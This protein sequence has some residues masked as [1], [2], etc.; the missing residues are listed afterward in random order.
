M[1]AQTDPRRALTLAA[2]ARGRAAGDV[3]VTS[4]AERAMGLAAKELNDLDG[5]E[6]HLRRAA[7]LAER[8]GLAVPEAEA[9]MSLALTLAYRGRTAAALAQAD[10][11]APVLSGGDAARLQMQRAVILD[12]LGRPDEALDGYRRALTVFRQQGDGL[13]E[14]RLLCNRGVLH[15]YRSELGAARADLR[16]ALA[17]SEQLGQLQ[18]VG[19][20]CHNLGFVETRAGDVPGALAW[21]DRA[22]ELWR[23]LEVPC[24]VLLLDRSE[25][26]LSVGLYEE[27]RDAAARAVAE[28]EGAS[29]AIDLA[30]ARLMLAQAAL[31]ADDPG[32][33]HH[34]ALLAERAFVRQRRRSWAVLARYGR[35]RAAWASGER[36]PASLVNARRV[37]GELHA[38][39]WAV[40][41]LDARLIAG[42][43]ALELG[44]TDTARTELAKAA[45]ARRRG[46]VDL[47]VRAWHAEGLRR[48]ADGDRRGADRAL[49][50]GVHLVHRY[51][52]ALGAADLRAHSASHGVELAGVGLR[53]AIG[54]GRPDR[55][56]AWAE[57]ARAGV[58]IGRPARPPDDDLLVAE[59]AELRQV[60]GEL[61]GAA[62]DGRPTARL[63]RRRAELE[64]AVRRR[65]RQAR[66][67][68]STPGRGVAGHPG[69]ARGATGG[70]RHR[71]PVGRP[72]PGRAGRHRRR[73]P[74]CGPRSRPA[75]PGHPRRDHRRGRPGRL[76]ALRPAATGDRS[77]GGRL[78]GGRP[79][80][81]RPRR[82]GA[83]VGAGRSHRGRGRRPPPRAHP[84]RSAARH[85]VGRPARPARPAGDGRPVGRPV[86]GRVGPGGRQHGG[87][88]GAAPAGRRTQPAA[89]RSPWSPVR[90]WPGLRP[91]SPNWPPATRTR[92]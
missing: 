88:A 5:A 81:V 14:A 91:R 18:L 20:V 78:P 27:G 33:A 79:P 67:P 35:A 28:L 64:E 69:R 25:L 21:Y 86:A 15:G 39:G 44:R 52:D 61:H 19:A 76:V 65:T 50:A 31:F 59:L 74:R 2:A 41:A 9:R 11:A 82:R 13:W 38:A 72:R 40:A 4:R 3:A 49:R 32:A 68:D 26:L 70:R 29:M 56:L 85:P 46:P 37:A 45:Q 1:L 87:P 23:S 6:R 58:L 53:L 24:A 62:V 66:R 47:R 48:L 60:T 43:I 90:A 10:R 16:R 22:E 12:R 80:A 63:L 89:R 7:G 71:R 30:E 8:A 17:L 83:P 77:R 36:T 57:R 55:V 34:Q 73:P 92:A 51:R 54:G 42:R 84:D 75:P